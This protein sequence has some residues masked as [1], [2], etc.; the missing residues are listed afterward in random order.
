MSQ[1]KNLKKL[2][3]E[4]DR[5]DEQIHDLLIA[6]FETSEKIGVLKGGDAVYF[7]PA[8]EAELLKTLINR[9]RG[10]LPAPVLV[11]LWREILSSS[12]ALQGDFCV[13]A[14]GKGN[15][16]SCRT[17]AED[18]FSRQAVSSGG[19]TV[20]TVLRSVS[21]GKT[22]VGVLPFPGS[23]DKAGEDW[24]TL[25]L[26]R[27]QSHPQNDGE[28][29]QVIGRLPFC[30]TRT[31]LNQRQ[32][33][34]MVA[35]TPV[36]PTGDDHSFLVLEAVEKLSR[37]AL[38]GL[39]DGSDLDSPLILGESCREGRFLYLFEVAG[40]F[41]P[42][43]ERLNRFVTRNRDRVIQIVSIGAFARPILLDE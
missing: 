27:P 19:T 40:F 28:T 31:A 37:S 12:T 20:K 9:H 22:A 25:I 14:F 23:D 21:A 4:I 34:I 2:R 16:Q 11:R 26:P 6:R 15:N 1:N 42:D 18:H 8:R 7:R 36:D 30:T 41:S 17:L 29:L 33:A 5:I 35:A 39:M 43:D 32:G 10:R 38:Q 13:S 3:T 24:W